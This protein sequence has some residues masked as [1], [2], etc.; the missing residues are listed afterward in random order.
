MKNEKKKKL[1]YEGLIS[2]NPPPP[3]KKNYQKIYSWWTWQAADVKWYLGLFTSTSPGKDRLFPSNQWNWLVN[4]K[5]SEWQWSLKQE[6]VIFERIAWNWIT[7]ARILK[8]WQSL[9]LN[10][11]FNFNSYCLRFFEIT[12][13]LN[14]ILCRFACRT[15]NKNKLNKLINIDEDKLWLLFF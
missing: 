11:I 15:K 9:E 1:R 2:S 5:L 10:F 12:F 14:L 6:G 7:S 13:F 8:L 3:P 4:I